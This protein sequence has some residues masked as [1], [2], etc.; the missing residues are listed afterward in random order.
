MADIEETVEGIRAFNR[1]YTANMGFLNADY[2]DGRFSVAETRILFE[3]YTAKDCVQSDIVKALSIDKSYLCRIIKKLCKLGLVEKERC[4]G[5][6]RKAKLTLTSY[7]AEETERLID[8]TNRR[9]CALIEG[10]DGDERARL[11]EALDTVTSILGR[12]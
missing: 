2:L 6:E 9:L 12:R 8:L 10:L 1:F 4:R 3:I 5:D 7:G 11:C